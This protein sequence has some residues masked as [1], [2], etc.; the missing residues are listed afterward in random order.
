MSVSEQKW[1]LV[2]GVLSLSLMDVLKSGLCIRRGRWKV[3]DYT[4]AP[5]RKTCP[6]SSKH[7]KS[8]GA[9]VRRPATLAE[10]TGSLTL[11][12][13]LSALLPLSPHHY[14]RSTNIWWWN[15]GAQVLN[16]LPLH[17]QSSLS[18]PI[19]FSK[20]AKKWCLKIMTLHRPAHFV[21]LAELKVIHLF[22]SRRLNNT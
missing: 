9:N 10:I 6:W 11:A 13:Q 2:S 1:A 21:H 20:F 8:D 12:F 7:L 17:D 19:F 3:T 15:P 16:Y 22:M 14:I 4:N 5:D 18:F